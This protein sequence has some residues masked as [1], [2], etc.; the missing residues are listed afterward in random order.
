MARVLKGQPAAMSMGSNFAEYLERV[1]DLK[2]GS[3][4]IG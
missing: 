2:L 1:S 4:E 3:P